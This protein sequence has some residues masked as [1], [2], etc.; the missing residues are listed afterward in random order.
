MSVLSNT[1]IRMGASGGGGAETGVVVNSLRFNSGDSAYLNRTPSDAG[2]RKTW[3]WSGWVKRNT[4]GTEQVIWTAGASTSSGEWSVLRFRA[5]PKT[6][7]LQFANNTGST[8]INLITT[9]RFRDPSAWMHIVLRADISNSTE[10][11][12]IDIFINGV[13]VDDYLTQTQPATTVDT[14]INGDQIHNIGREAAGTTSYC[15]LQ[16]ADVHFVDGT[17]LDH[18]SF[19]EEDATTGQWVPI[20]YTHVDATDTY[21]V[22]NNGTTW[23]NA[24]TVDSGDSFD[25][26]YPKTNAFDGN[27]GNKALTA[28]GVG[29]TSY[30]EMVFS[31]AISG[32]L[33]VN[34]DNGNT[35]R[36]VTGG[37][38]VVLAT[39]STGSD[40]QWVS[41]GTVSSLTNLR[42]LMSG[43]SRPGIAAIELD[44][45]TF[46][47]GA[48]SADN[49]FHL[50]FDNTSDLGEDSSGNDNDWTANN[51][52]TTAGTDNDV[53]SDSPSTYDD[54]GNGVG[55]YATWNPLQNS[56]GTLSNGNL[57]FVGSSGWEQTHGTI[58]G[59]TSGKWY[60]E[61]TLLNNPHSQASNALYNIFGWTSNS[62]T[63][64]DYDSTDWLGF[65]DTGWYRNFGSQ[66]NSSTT[67]VSGGVISISVD[68]DNNTFNFRYNNLSV[69]SG[70]IGGT[71]GR[72]LYPFYMNY[73][74]TYGRMAAN[75]G[76]RAFAYTPPTGYKALNTFNLDDPTITDGTEH[77]D[78]KLYTGTGADL[79][80]GG[81]KFQPGLLWLKNRTD[82]STRHCLMDAISGSDLGFH[83]DG[84][85]VQQ[86]PGWD[87]VI[88][89]D[90]DSDGFTASPH[91][92]SNASSKEYVAWVWD[93]GSSTVTNTDG[94]VD[95]E[96]RANPS[97]GFSIV[98]FTPSTDS[99]VGHGLNA[100]PSVVIY[101]DREAISKW[102]FHHKDVGVS[103]TLYLNVNEA[104]DANT[105]R[106][107]A[108]TS[109]TFTVGDIVSGN[110]H[111]AYCW[112]EVEGYSKFGSWVGRSG[113]SFVYLG[114]K[115]RFLLGKCVS[116][117]GDWMVYDTER[118]TFNQ[119]AD[120]NTLVAN[121]AYAENDGS[122]YYANQTSVDLLSNGFKIRHGGSP[123]GDSGRT[124]IYAAFAEYPFKY[125]NAR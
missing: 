73:S 55:N 70:T 72:A 122:W 34:C 113:Y 90:W 95:S 21:H 41:C 18:T 49:S 11:D 54:E 106:V 86:G 60:Y 30:L 50:K 63:T 23:S 56:G 25:G 114:F 67:M 92:Y 68:L 37:G 104:E 118:D 44:G 42:V 7:Q 58:G 38:D 75:F 123:L 80:I 121:E 93:A 108:V 12:R 28:N 2:N 87:G 20:E 115:P 39:Q 29:G 111:T 13:K 62:D 26:S 31:P 36:N 33:R 85:E 47:D 105:D 22:I 40:N 64:T 69:L 46:I 16:L 57:E 83:I 6:D 45:V 109:T 103:K 112:S 15:D 43:G 101:K 48:T 98:N 8:D 125:S 65:E 9:Q 3:T 76:Q 61:M 107:T 19:G 51:F 5:S 17:A 66:T 99:S 102:R 124:Y 79:V 84:T 110:D 119:D 59:L 52:S 14:G 81:M 78:T 96:V 97:A 24:L 116:N 120:N 77:F 27:T 74:A 89:S 1:G 88:T 82:N 4:L 32:V 117:L 94:S 35:V 100:T 10:N 91:S 53:L 71:A